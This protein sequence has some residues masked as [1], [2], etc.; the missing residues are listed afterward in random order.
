MSLDEVLRPERVQAAPQRALEV[1]QDTARSVPAYRAWLR[2]QGVDV[3][4]IARPSA[5]A[6]VPVMTKLNYVQR[7]P[8]AERCRDGALQACDMVAVSS[9]STGTP[10]FWPRAAQDEYAVA[11]RFEQVFLDGFQADR[12]STLAVVCFALGTWVGGLYT[13]HCCRLLAAKGWPL[14]VV[15]PGNQMREILR[16]IPELAPAFDQVVLLGYPPFLKDVVD[17][18]LAQGVD[19][20]ALRVKFVTAGEVFSEAFRD[21]LL[22][23]VGAGAPCHDVAALYGTADG[24]VLGNETPLSIAVR[25]LLAER[26]A[27]AERLFGEAR[28]PALLQYD[29]S[30]RYFEVAADGTLLITGDNGVPLVRYGILDKGGL[31]GFT[32][33]LDLLAV[34]GLDPRS[35]LDA[36]TPVRPLPF[37]FLFGRSDFTVSFYGA[38]VFPENVSVAL[39]S[40]EVSAFVTGKFVLYVDDGADQ[41]KR[42]NLAVELAPGQTGDA[43]RVTLIRGAVLAELA[44]QNSEWVEYV[45]ADRKAPEV[46][47]WPTGTPEYFPVGVKHRYTR[48]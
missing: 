18:G 8:L 12:K 5:L 2:E 35:L 36:R 11:R 4:E 26:P 41:N 1:F 44:R 9:G 40:Q 34:E 30:E 15:A 38:N 20:S 7:Y 47:L 10:T 21:L 28:M 25:R 14:T 32:E 46:T 48:K 3:G 45:P 23:R 13:E 22:E 37:V 27:L 39:E 19:W 43:G 24:G 31:F 17:T 33:L 6:Q 42:L 29:P 16:V